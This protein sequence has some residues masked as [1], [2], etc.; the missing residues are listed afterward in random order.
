MK[1]YKLLLAVLFVGALITSLFSCK[2]SDGNRVP[3][4]DDQA[5]PG[6]VTNI[7]VDNYNGG[8][9][10]TYTLPDSKNILYVQA[11]YQIR[12]G[13]AR[14]TKSSYYSD[15]LNVEGFSKEAD[16]EVTLTTVTRSNV[17]SDPVKVIVHPKI[18]PYISIKGSASLASDFGGVNVIAQNPL[19]KEIGVVLVAFDKATNKMEIQDQHYTTDAVINYSV[20]GYNTDQRQFGVYVTDRFGNISDTLQSAITPL[21]E[22]LFNKSN[23]SVYRLNSDT[24]LLSGNGWPVQ[25]LWDNQTNGSS[26]GWHTQPGHVP[27]FVCT[28]NVGNLYK[29]SRF[30]VWERPDTDNNKF[31]FAH[32]NPREFSLWGSN[33]A[34]PQDAVLPITAPVG[35]VV[36]DWFNIGNYT[37]PNPPSGL[38]PLA[39][40][41]ADNQFVL[42]G[43]NFSVPLNTPPVKFMRV[44]VTSTWS[45]GNFAHLMELSFYGK[46]Q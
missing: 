40:N 7:K 13:V 28:F 14:E 24:E 30:V 29:R 27:P 9:Y 33:K 4:S 35:A 31:A 36:G 23:F 16:Y 42:A 37:F 1:K 21:F 39:H 12:N 26:L 6:V 2:K 44:S 32:G 43:V 11:K 46:L 34:S 38:P 41:E 22:Q 45:G 17:Q 25:N 10:I 20:R 5:K 18:P 8:S 19:K 3:V 15:T